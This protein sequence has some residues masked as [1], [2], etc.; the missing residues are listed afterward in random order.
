MR[1]FLHRLPR[2]IEDECSVPP[3]FEAGEPV[4]EAR[5]EEARGVL[6][7]LEGD[8]SFSG[9]VPLVGEGDGCADVAESDAERVGQCER[10]GGQLDLPV[11]ARV[12]STVMGTRIGALV[13]A[14]ALLPAGVAGAAT[15]TFASGKASGDY[16]IAMAT[17]TIK[18]PG[19]LRVKITTS[20]DQKVSV[21]WT[22]VC[23][24]GSGAGSKGGQFDAKTPLSRVMKKPGSGS[25]DCTVSANAQLSSSGSVRVSLVG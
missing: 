6:F 4:V 17:G 22:M 12:A 23:L 11:S 7:D 2:G 24:N 21:S 25:H 14:V 18:R 8:I 15:K 9:G 10:I 5:G 16:A 20:P 13:L 3:R 19:T 1:V